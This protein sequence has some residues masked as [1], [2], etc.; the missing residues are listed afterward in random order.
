VN[1]VPSAPANCDLT[2]PTDG[3]SDGKIDVRDIGL[4]ARH[5]GETG[6]ESLLFVS[7]E[8]FGEIDNN[9][10][11]L[12][13]LSPEQRNWIAEFSSAFSK[14]LRVKL[15]YKLKW[16]NSLFFAFLILLLSQRARRSVFCLIRFSIDHSSVYV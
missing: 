3:V 2:G 10:Q 7:E 16:K 12:F 14:N 5:F 1:T 13:G 9:L 15:A 11:Q 6:P 4:V 8:T